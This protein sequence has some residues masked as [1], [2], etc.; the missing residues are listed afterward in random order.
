MGNKGLSCEMVPNDKAVCLGHADSLVLDHFD[1]H[2]YL[3][4]LAE[5]EYTVSEVSVLEFDRYEPPQG[6]RSCHRYLEL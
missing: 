6:L 3:I 2:F 1:Q 4:F 5:S